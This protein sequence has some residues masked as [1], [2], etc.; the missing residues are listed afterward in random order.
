MHRESPAGTPSGYV[1]PTC[2]GALWEQQDREATTA[3]ECRV[4]HA[5]SAEQL[6]V[7]HCK[8]RNQTLMMA[9]RSLAENAALARDLAELGRVMGRESVAARLENEA[10]TEEGYL[11][12]VRA[13][14]ADFATDE[15]PASS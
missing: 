13:M 2:G 8:R 7:T 1:C 15:T 14:L 4:G 12:Q 6:W 3:Y 5:F 10:A 11:T 9:E